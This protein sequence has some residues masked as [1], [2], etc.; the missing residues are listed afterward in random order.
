MKNMKDW[1]VAV[2]G[3]GTMGL[4]IAQ[5]FSSKGLNTKL[6]NRTEANLKKAYQLI[7]NNLEAMVSLDA[8]DGDMHVEKVMGNL[9]CT[10]DIK[11]AVEDADIIFECVSEDAELKKRIFAEIDLYA[12]DRA[13]ICSDTSALNIYEFVNTGRPNKILITHFFNPAHVMPLVEIVKGE[14]TPDETAQIIKSFLTKMGK[15]P[16]IISKCIPGFIFNRLLTA[17]ER[18]AL[19]IVE[20][21]VATYDE[22]DTVITTTLGPRFAFEGIFDLLD[23]V[24]LD[25][26][27]A[28]VGDLIP[29]LCQSLEAPSLLL[30]K[31]AAGEYGVKTGRGF[32]N[33]NGM[34]VDEIRRQRTIKII[35]TFRHIDTL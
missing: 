22:I 14:D 13:Y 20:Q 5:H 21:G 18:E 11:I 23:H 2:V 17:L 8:L 19:Y 31:A 16:I 30:N 27:A 29:Q 25:T 7:K 32:K 28:V 10:T 35:K 26:E 3:A 33:Y 4:C 24:G 6:Y 1:N 12:P 34:D 15:K 9:T